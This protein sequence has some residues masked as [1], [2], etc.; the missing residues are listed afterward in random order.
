FVRRHEESLWSLIRSV[1]DT[2]EA[3]TA[4][5]FQGLKTGADS[6]FVGKL[7]GASGDTAEFVSQVDR[8]VHNLEMALVYPLAKGGQMRRYQLEPSEHCISFPDRDG[9][10]IPWKELEEC[11]PQVAAYLRQTR[12][13]LE[14]RD[15]GQMRGEWWYGYSRNQALRSVRSPKIPVPDYYAHASYCLDPTGE[16]M[17]CGGGAGGYGLIPN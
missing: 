1:P 13:T 10:L 8:A 3:F 11:F 16:V 12:S 17:F 5:I 2:L 6:V 14:A 4:E 15:R 7:R 9:S